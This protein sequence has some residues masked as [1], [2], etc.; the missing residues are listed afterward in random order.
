MGHGGRQ[1][2]P[3]P[4]AWTEVWSVVCHVGPHRLLDPLHYMLREGK[5]GRG[6]YPRDAG[7]NEDKRGVRFRRVE[8]PHLLPVPQ[9]VDVQPQNV[10]QPDHPCQACHPCV[11]LSCPGDPPLAIPRGSARGGGATSEVWWSLEEIVMKR[12][13]SVSPTPRKNPS[14]GSCHPPPISSVSYRFVE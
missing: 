2:V 7:L 10:S 3:E 1:G 6:G 13:E 5:G 11:R 4:E 8:Q 12:R 14:S 9:C